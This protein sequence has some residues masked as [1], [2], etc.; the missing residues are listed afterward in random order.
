MTFLAAV[1]LY[2]ALFQIQSA[3]ACATNAEKP[4]A[5]DWKKAKTHYLNEKKETPRRPSAQGGPPLLPFFGGSGPLMAWG[6]P[7]P[8]R[9]RP[10]AVMT[11][12]V[13]AAMNDAWWNSKLQNVRDVTIAV[14]TQFADSG[15]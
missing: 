5:S 6:G 15:F 8:S 1:L 4:S 13:S 12:A 10:E 3:S 2:T 14:P 7:N 11:N 9:W